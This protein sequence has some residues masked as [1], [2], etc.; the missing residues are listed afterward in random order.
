MVF[1]FAS[2]CILFMKIYNDAFEERERYRVL[3]KLGISQKTLNKA[4]ANEL[5]FSYIIPLL[6]M[7]IS[8]YF[9]VK[10]F[11]NLMQSPSLL[12]VNMI[13]VLIIYAFFLICY[14]LSIVIYRKNIDV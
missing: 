4:I 12:S 11:A 13:S 14:F 1:V 6:V 2:G 8:S 10:A 9:S 5:R 7:T 3:S